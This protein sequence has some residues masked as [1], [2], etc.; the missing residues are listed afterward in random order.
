MAGDQLGLFDAPEEGTGL[1]DD[2][3]GVMDAGRGGPARRRGP[4]AGRRGARRDRLTVHPHRMTR[5]PRGA[6]IL[7]NP[8]GHP[9]CQ[10]SEDPP[11]GEPKRT[12]L[13]FLGFDGEGVAQSVLG[14][15]ESG[16]ADKAITV[17]DWAM[18]HKAP[19]GKL[20]ITK[21]TRNGPGR[22]PWRPRRRRRGRGARG[23]VGPDRRRGGRGRRGDRRGHRGGQGFGLQ[24]PRHQGDLE[25]DGRRPDRDHG[26][27]AARRPWTSGTRSSPT[28][29]SSP[30]RTTSTRS[31]SCPGRTLEDAI[32]EYRP[33]RGRRPRLTRLPVSGR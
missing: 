14:V 32:E 31:T 6:R 3:I 16:I 22:G 1:P 18:V 10:P 4:G 19:G 33:P 15:I 2:A 8:A 26:R 20:T 13:I 30:R 25:A 11:M 21:N 12:R 5:P 27:R 9:A 28:T 23:P 24:G 29:R 17:E 7:S